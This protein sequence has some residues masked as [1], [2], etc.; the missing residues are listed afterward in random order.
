[1]M[2]MMMIMIII[3]IIITYYFRV[4]KLDKYQKKRQQNT[5]SRN[6]IFETGQRLHTK[7]FSKKWRRA[8]WTK[9]ICNKRKNNWIQRKMETPHK[10]NG[11]WE[12]TQK[13]TS[14]NIILSNLFLPDA[15]F[16]E[17]FCISCGFFMN[18]EMNILRS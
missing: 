4:W 7:R 2:M 12:S 16:T 5:G 17:L 13:N 3:I 11:K 15:R 14:T 10:Q 8:K 1:M 9:C 18:Y 6:E